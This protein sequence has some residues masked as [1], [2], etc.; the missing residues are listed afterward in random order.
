MA[1][2]ARVNAT[3]LPIDAGRR[4]L[5]DHREV[6]G[7]EALERIRTIAAPLADVSVLCL[8]S[9]DATGSQAPN[10]LR[11]LLPLMA[12]VGVEVR[13]RALAG[14]DARAGR[15]VARAGARRGGVRGHRDRVGRV[16]RAESASALEPEL[17]QADVVVV[18]DAAALGCVAAA[19][20]GAPRCAWSRH[21]DASA[22]DPVAARAAG[23]A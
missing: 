9:A 14:G 19:R 2:L 1:T 7:E 4:P 17:A 8:T 5:D 20:S 16:G 18:H 15:R 3:L 13:W 22:A 6:A 11:S 10:Y 23:R 12:D 21:E